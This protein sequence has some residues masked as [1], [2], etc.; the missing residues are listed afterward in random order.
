MFSPG[1]P[2]PIGSVQA[3]ASLASLYGVDLLGNGSSL[4]YLQLLVP[5]RDIYRLSDRAALT[6]PSSELFSRVSAFISNG[7]R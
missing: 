1:G 6:D 4:G 7:R 3:L 5:L 2:I